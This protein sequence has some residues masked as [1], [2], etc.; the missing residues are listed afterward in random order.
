MNKITY[1]IL[2]SFSLRLTLYIL[3][4]AATVFVVTILFNYYSAHKHVHREATERAQATLDNT[5]LQI[6]NVMNSVET[7]VHSIAWLIPTAL[8]DSEYMYSLTRKLIESSPYIL[9]SA[10]AFEPDYFPDKG[11]YFSPYSYHN[12]DSI[13]SIQLGTA[14]YDYHYM[15]CYQIPKLLNSRY[16]SEPYYDTGGA[17]KIM[18]T[19]SY[20]LY[21]ADGRLYAIF[22]ADISLEWLASMVN[23]IKPYPNSWN[24]M[25]GRGGSYLVHP[26]KEAILN[27][28][29]F[30]ASI[31]SGN[32]NMNATGHRMVDGEKGM[33]MLE[34]D[35]ETLYFFYAP[36]KATGWSVAVVCRHSD[37]FSGIVRM[38]NVVFILAL[39]GLL[40][41]TLLCYYTIRKLT[42]P[43]KRF[44][45]SA[46]EIAHGDF[47]AKLPVIRSRDE[48]R[49]LCDSFR[50]M[51][52]SLRKY[53]EELRTT[54]ANNERIES[55]LCIARNI[56]MGMLPKT[57]PPFPERDDIELSANLVPAREVGGDLYDFFIRDNK[58]YFIVGDVSGKG[59]PASLVMAVTCRLFR[60]TASHL[61]SPSEIVS[62]L[63]DS[64]AES[65]E[66]CMFCT[67]FLGILDLKS[68]RLEYCNAG[69]NAPIIMRPGGE[70]QFM[71][72]NTNV[73]LGLF[74]GFAYE[75]ESCTVEKGSV[76]FLYTDGITEAEN[77]TKELFSDERLLALFDGESCNP[78][79][80]TDKV[81]KSVAAHASGV[82]QS[83][84]I[85]IMCLRFK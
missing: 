70:A 53:I 57:F 25:I 71:A 62:A 4:T 8:E 37:I 60:T 3:F 6:D 59:V 9:G 13:V 75:H 2:R 81:M 29:M 11:R 17:N 47:N 18:T 55:E 32:K 20:P 65:N 61:S 7:A 22:T 78:E 31:Y 12:G 42:M 85:T 52:G 43:L 28:S 76:L 45:Q 35:G 73:P 49:S 40:L 82:E 36:V 54:T 30:A 38:R 34:Y 77:S 41:M 21:D 64:L 23:S 50:Y 72:V 74:E 68:G 67:F 63:N 44:A 24:L 79:E 26:R 58:L 15:D 66:T 14:D 1:S 39:V 56:Q 80:L 27:E 5:I 51:Q 10:I 84:D 19:Y 46:T 83:D 69:H 16:W 33:T 48:M